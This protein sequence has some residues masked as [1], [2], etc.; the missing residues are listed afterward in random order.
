M[1]TGDSI[2]A[3][4]MA[5]VGLVAA[6]T[7]SEAATFTVTNTNDA[8]AGSLRQ[9]VI[10]ANGAAG[11]DTI[12]FAAAVTGTITL[13]S[14]QL[15]ISDSVTVNGPG[16]ANLSVSGNN[17]SRVF[18]LY[19][20]AGLIDVTINDLRITNGGAVSFGGGIINFG[21]NLTLD[22]V[23]IENC[24]ATG[25]GAGLAATDISGDLMNTV[26]RDST[27]SGNTTGR[28]GGVYFYTTGGALTI[29]NSVISGNTATTSDGGGVYLYHSTGA[30]TITGSTIS[31]NTAPQLGGGIYLYQVDGAGV[32]IDSTT[33]SGNSGGYGGGMFTIF[34]DTPVALRNV[35]VS[36]N[37]A[38]G[39]FGGAFFYYGTSVS[40]TNTTVVD[41]TAPVA[42]AVGGPESIDIALTGSILANSTAT[43]DL[44]GTFT[45]QGSLIEAPGGAIINDGGGNIL[46]QDPQLGALAN[47]GGS[48]ETHLPAATSPVINA[49]DTALT[50][51]QRGVARPS[52]AN[53]DIGSVEVRQSTILVSTAAQTVAEEAGTVT[54]TVQ[55]TAGDGAASVD[56]NATDGSALVVSDYQAASGTLS[57]AAGDTTDRTV[58]ITLV[59]DAA[60]EPTET[61]NL[62]LTAPVNAALGAATQVITITDGDVPASNIDF[63]V[64]GMTVV[65][66][67]LNAQVVLQRTGGSAGA[68]SV[69]LDTANGTAIAPFDYSATST[70]VNWANNDGA[71]KTVLIPIVDDSLAENPETFTATLTAPAGANLGPNQ[72]LNVTIGDNDIVPVP[73]DSRWA[74]LGGA[75][76]L[77]GLGAF[78]ARRHKS[79][80][81]PLAGMVLA[82]GAAGML[83]APSADAAPPVRERIAGVVTE[84]GVQ[85]R[86]TTIRLADGRSV[87]ADSDDVQVIDR[88]NR[89]FGVARTLADVQTGTAVM[90][91]TVVR[92]SGAD[93][94]VRIVLF[95]DLAA[96]EAAAAK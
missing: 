69:T 17:A 26:I 58:N 7:D 20:G 77:L 91:K 8:G 50:V 1:N 65:E 44:V 36:G 87:T 85:A 35:T 28:G 89:G 64:T 16:A 96:A 12:E 2:K 29:E 32:T 95:R 38:S 80:A 33:I 90:V 56:Y 23:T 70:V 94:R 34:A 51:D 49:F 25:G 62:V 5:V 43:A 15:A 53:D 86:Q 79:N 30:T 27:I 93:R 55:R 46:N 74:I 78:A 48:T 61:F 3:G 40:L 82:L 73:V 18:Y 10:D 52:G 57:W 84:T 37:T 88:R 24:A 72:V 42:G 92:D 75:L 54:V 14:G 19:S 71:D 22:S 6:S 9:A 66:G 67:T 47:N 59:D 39:D 21:E 13:T 63:T 41:N 31:G 76:G 60:Q 4:G 83:G 45:A 11:A 81:G 68:A